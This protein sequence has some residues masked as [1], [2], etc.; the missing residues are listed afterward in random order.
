[1]DDRERKS[2]DMTTLQL[3]MTVEDKIWLQ[4]MAAEERTTAAA[5]VREWIAERREKTNGE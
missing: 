3:S 2:T 1:M 4:K 5:L